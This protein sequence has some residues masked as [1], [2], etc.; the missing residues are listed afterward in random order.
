M[1]ASNDSKNWIINCERIR[2]KKQNE[3]VF[4]FKRKAKDQLIR[5]STFVL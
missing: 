1:P 3:I 4:V 2:K 5:S